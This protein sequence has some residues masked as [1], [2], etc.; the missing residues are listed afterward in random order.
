V[1]GAPP[2]EPPAVQGPSEAEWERLAAD[3]DNYTEA[4]RALDAVGGF[5][6]ALKSASADQLTKLADIARF[7]SQRGR[8]LQALRLL[9]DRFPNAQEAPEAAW[10]LG[11][12]LESQGDVPRAL[13][14]FALYRRLSPHGDFVEDAASRPVKLAI[15]QGDLQ[16]ARELLDRYAKEFPNGGHLAELQSQLAGLTSDVGPRDENQS[17]SE[18]SPAP[19]LDPSAA[20]SP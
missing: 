10:A 15:E 9:L 18:S 19:S 16:K 13:E 5:D 1:I 3:P 7:N 2:L 11:N 6:E 12:M 17:K 14:A 20:K 4:W 8:A